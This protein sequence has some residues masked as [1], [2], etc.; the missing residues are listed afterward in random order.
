M[1][2]VEGTPGAVG[3]G[4][5]VLA[6]LVAAPVERDLGRQ[7]LGGLQRLE[8]DLEGVRRGRERGERQQRR[9]VPPGPQCRHVVL[10]D[11]EFIDPGPVQVVAHDPAADVVQVVGVDPVAHDPVAGEHVLGFGQ[12]D[13]PVGGAGIGSA[14]VDRDDPVLR[15]VQIRQHPEVSP[16]EPD[17]EPGRGTDH[18]RFGLPA[19]AQI[20]QIHVGPGPAVLHG[21]DHVAAVP[22]LRKPDEPLRA[23][24]LAEQLHIVGHVRAQQVQPHPPARLARPAHI[25]EPAAVLVERHPAVEVLRQPV[26]QV[27]AGRQIAHPDRDL[28]APPVPDR[29]QHETAVR[30]EVA[31]AHA[32]RAVRVD[33]E[34]IDHHLEVALRVDRRVLALPGR[35]PPVDGRHLPARP[36]EREVLVVAGTAGKER[37]GERP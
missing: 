7:P 23:V 11:R 21:V 19:G 6:D 17:A 22:T 2:D 30:R 24:S 16:D 20:L 9:A 14:R 10:G 34:R 3:G 4:V 32:G 15:R 36:A 27:L 12:H 31:D 37:A 33:V 26:R 13:A 1:S 5:P 35:R 8:V 18:D 25:A 28:V 29:V